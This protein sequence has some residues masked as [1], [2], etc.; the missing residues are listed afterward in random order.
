[1]RLCGFQEVDPTVPW[2]EIVEMLQCSGIISLYH[3]ALVSPFAGPSTREKLSAANKLATYSLVRA[4]LKKKH[5]WYEIPSTCVILIWYY[6]GFHPTIRSMS[7]N[8]DRSDTCPEQRR[9]EANRNETPELRTWAKSVGVTANANQALTAVVI[10][11]L[12]LSILCERRTLHRKTRARIHVSSTL[13]SN[14]DRGSR[15]SNPYLLQSKP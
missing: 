10:P 5:H 8:V 12:F 3:A 14:W 4:I 6:Y 11:R 1:M 15:K 7:F 13:C 9:P 2:M